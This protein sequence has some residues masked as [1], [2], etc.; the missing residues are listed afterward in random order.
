MSQLAKA[1]GRFDAAFASLPADVQRAVALAMYRA[2]PAIQQYQRDLEP[3]AANDEIK[4][5]L[6][7]MFIAVGFRLVM[8]GKEAIGPKQIDE[9]KAAAPATADFL[10]NVGRML[11]GLLPG[12]APTIDV[13]P[14]NAI[15]DRAPAL[16]PPDAHVV[17]DPHARHP[18]PTE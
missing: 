13:T 1:A 5:A 4:E 8:K 6:W 9:M 12:F 10:L 17:P 14:R 2:A 7:D 15:A 16:E 3:L 11:E 18:E